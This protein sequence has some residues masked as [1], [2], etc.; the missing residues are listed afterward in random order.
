MD[1]QI[2]NVIDAA[3]AEMVKRSLVGNA[4]V[5]VHINSPGGSVTDALAIYSI[6]RKHSGRIT[7]IVD[8]LCASAATIIMLAADEVVMAEHSL[9]MVHNPWTVASGDAGEMRKTAET[10]DKAASEMTAL[11]AERTGLKDAAITA[12]MEAET[13]YNAYEAVE[14]GFAH[15]VD[16]DTRSKPRMAAAAVA[17]L[18]EVVQ[19][20]EAATQCRERLGS[21]RTR[22][23]AAILQPFAGN[24]AVTELQKDKAIMSKSPEQIQAAVLQALGSETT[25]SAAPI[26]AHIHVGNGNIVRAGM[27]DA[28]SAR[29]GIAPAQDRNNPFRTMSMVDM[30]R[31]SLTEHGVGVAAYGNKMQ[32]VGAAFTHH[33]GDFGSVLMD[34]SQ[35]TMLK[36]WE[37]SGE[38]FPLWTKKGELSNFHTGHRVGMAGFPTL[39]KVPEGAEYTYVSTSDR[40]API[41]LATYGGLFSITRQAIINDDLSAFSSIPG[42]LGRAASR[43]IGELVYAVLTTNANFIDGNPLF[44]TAHKNVITAGTMTP[45]VLGEA[46]TKMRL[47]KD[48][49]GSALNIAPGFMIVPASLESIARQVLTSTAVPGSESN[50][51]IANPV[52]N[53]SQLIV[54]SRLDDVSGQEWYLV[55]AQGSDTIEVAYLDGVDAPYLEQQQ[56]WT[57][58]GVSF[59]VRI[60]AGVAPLDYR[61]MVAAQVS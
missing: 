42:N 58:D 5:T 8:G 24:A 10:L 7:A 61:G 46:R 35:K 28:L 51:G 30:A 47:Q 15:R 6:L 19:F 33:T 18:A 32:L 41:A 43:T 49:N 4:A 36:G 31:A 2:Y 45:D 14:A 29:L 11:Y 16:A 3:T 20:P 12:I 22:Q 38:S 27:V 52:S 53:M 25:P 39:K 1:I 34:V 57:V 56:G 23:I 13:W 9:L 50:S 37:N 26:A 44:G 21:A 60:D 48:E 40:G 54:E 59:K 17:F 55:A